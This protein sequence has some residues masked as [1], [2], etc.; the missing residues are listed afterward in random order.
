MQICV[1]RTDASTSPPFDPKSGEKSSDGVAQL[2]VACLGNT[3]V[4]AGR[5]SSAGEAVGR[6]S[7]VAVVGEA[8]G[9][10]TVAEEGWKGTGVVGIGFGEPPGFAVA[11]GTG[12]PGSWGEE[13]YSGRC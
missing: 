12:A 2:A 7:F 5:E 3:L 6:E 13:E 4:A 1:R 10:A 8:V 9:M 11:G